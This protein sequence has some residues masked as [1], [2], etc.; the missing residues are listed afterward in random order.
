M[1]TRGGMKEEEWWT[2][3]ETDVKKLI[4]TFHNFAK[5]SEVFSSVNLTITIITLCQVIIE[6]IQYS[7]FENRVIL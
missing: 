7:H 1:K 4:I 6:N 3:G 2:D 5:A